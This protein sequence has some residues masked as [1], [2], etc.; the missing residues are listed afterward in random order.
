MMG[1]EK[2]SQGFLPNPYQIYSVVDSSS[3]LEVI[4]IILQ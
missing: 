3:H 2:E 1:R 4:K